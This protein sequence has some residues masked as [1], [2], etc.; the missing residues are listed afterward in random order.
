VVAL[1]S[2]ALALVLTLLQYIFF[3]LPL[4]DTIELFTL[5]THKCKHSRHHRTLLAND[6][7]G[8]NEEGGLLGL[9]LKNPAARSAASRI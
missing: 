4:C 2:F 9:S 5:A 8:G 1:V 6:S 7:S 3:S